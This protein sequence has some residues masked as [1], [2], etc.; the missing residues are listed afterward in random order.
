M[1][2]SSVAIAKLI[3]NITGEEIVYRDCF[4]AINDYTRDNELW[5]M[6]AVYRG[7]SYRVIKFV[8]DGYIRMYKKHP[9]DQNAPTIEI[10]L[11]PS[12]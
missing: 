5:F 1:A 8:D 4:C 6:D 9:L 10:K 2:F 3:K 11:I 7:E 12:F